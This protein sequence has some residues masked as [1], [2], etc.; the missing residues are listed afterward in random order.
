MRRLPIPV[1]VFGSLTGSLTKSPE[2]KRF[3]NIANQGCQTR[4]QGVAV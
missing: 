2:N 3:S 1:T 4:P